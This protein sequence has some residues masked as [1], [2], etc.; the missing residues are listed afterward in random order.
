MRNDKKDYRILL[1]DDSVEN[2]KMLTLLLEEEGY[3]VLQATGGLLGLDMADRTQPD[4]ILLDI[5]MREIDG[6]EVC[7]RLKEREGLKEIPVILVSG[8]DAPID[9]VR[10]YDVGGVD[11]ITRPIE[12]EEMLA[13]INTQ[14]TINRLRRELID[15]NISVE[16]KVL[17]RTQALFTANESLK[18]KIEEHTQVKEALQAGDW[19]SEP[20]AKL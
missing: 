12:K 8:L 3:R 7:R 4:L 20:K 17:E 1:I 18:L 14:L 11:Y 5:K 19:Q 15:A 6:Y 16:E 9:K 10:A 2:L 13:R